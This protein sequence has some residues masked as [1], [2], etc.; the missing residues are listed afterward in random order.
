MSHLWW[1][2]VVRREPVAELAWPVL[3]R[4]LRDLLHRLAEDD[5]YLATSSEALLGALHPQ[6]AEAELVRNA[7]ELLL[8]CG[9]LA[10]DDLGIRVVPVEAESDLEP[11]HLDPVSSDRVPDDHSGVTSEVVLPLTRSERAARAAQARW[12]RTN[13]DDRR[14]VSAKLHAAKQVGGTQ[15]ARSEH[16]PSTQGEHAGST[17]QARSD[18]ACLPRAVSGSVDPS[19]DIQREKEEIN[20]SHKTAEPDRARAQQARSEHAGSTQQARKVSTQTEHAT[21]A[22]SEHVVMVVNDEAE[23]DRPETSC[24]LDLYERAEKAGV[25]VDLATSLKVGLA[26]VR[27]HTVAFCAYWTIGAGMGLRRRQWLRRLRQRICDLHREGR[28]VLPTDRG[29][30][31]GLLEHEAAAEVPA[32]ELRRRAQAARARRE[33]KPGPASIGAITAALRPAGGSE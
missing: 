23:L 11:E 30:P 20:Q 10:E 14:A 12:S 28:L 22:R 6:P 3:A 5:G 32:D 24:P 15:A 13:R 27:H 16:A 18:F 7:I 9:F 4:G 26:E 1:R 2:K 33:A 31:P 21:H 19:G 8:Q 29:K 25:L 17:Q